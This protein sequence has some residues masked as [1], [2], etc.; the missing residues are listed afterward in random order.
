[1]KLFGWD[2]NKNATATEE[3]PCSPPVVVMDGQYELERCSDG[4]YLTNLETGERSYVTAG[5]VNKICEEDGI[6]IQVSS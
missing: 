3:F 1:M 5:Q 4:D 2:Q 6:C